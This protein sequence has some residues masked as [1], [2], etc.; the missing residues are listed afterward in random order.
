MAEEY[1]GEVTFFGVS[2]NDTVEAGL[3]YAESFDV[4]YDLAHA[5]EVWE[6]FDVP[7]QPVTILIGA[8]GGIAQRID[9][10]VT[11]EGLKEAIEQVL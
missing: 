6:A 4:P 11:Y 10:E 3:D 7:Y 1:E 5:P 2:N 9:G 8:D